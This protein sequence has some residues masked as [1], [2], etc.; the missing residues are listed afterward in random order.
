MLAMS[1]H[2]LT[3]IFTMI[4]KSYK[5]DIAGYRKYQKH[6]DYHDDDCYD[7]QKVEFLVC[8][9]GWR[10]L[11]YSDTIPIVGGLV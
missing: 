8:D 2:A 5:C 7:E 11:L 1:T 9:D 3:L 6:C 4:V 10:K